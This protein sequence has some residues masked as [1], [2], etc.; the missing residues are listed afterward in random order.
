MYSRF[1]MVAV[2]LRLY[3]VCGVRIMSMD[4][5]LLSVV[6]FVLQAV[7]DIQDMDESYTDMWH[8]AVQSLIQVLSVN[9]SERN[10][11][12][13]DPDIQRLMSNARTDVTPKS[14]HGL[15]LRDFQLVLYG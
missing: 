2:L 13:S 5:F 4:K 9:K 8:V 6:H 1:E 12:K 10:N 15:L 7:E 3:Q 14:A 11:L